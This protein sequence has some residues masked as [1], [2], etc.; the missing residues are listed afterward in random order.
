MQEPPASGESRSSSHLRRSSDDSTVKTL[1]VTQ[2]SF[3]THI[4]I[5]RPEGTTSDVKTEDIYSCPD[6][7]AAWQHRIRSQ[8]KTPSRKVLPSPHLFACYLTPPA[9]QTLR[10]PCILRCS[11]V[12]DVPRHQVSKD[13]LMSII[14]RFHRLQRNSQILEIGGTN[15][16][17]RVD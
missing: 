8:S 5:Y 3:I 2:L 16:C 9:S 7:S 1:V 14:I 13:E 4:P 10:R 12:S 17:R 6:E 15:Q 11:T